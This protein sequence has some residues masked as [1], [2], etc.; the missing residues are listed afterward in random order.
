M[1]GV[2]LEAA[3][4]RLEEGRRGS[5]RSLRASGYG[6]TEA[7]RRAFAR[8]LAVTRGSTAGS[9]PRAELRWRG[10]A[11]TAR[12]RRRAGLSPH[13]PAVTSGEYRRKFAAEL[14][15]SE[16]LRAARFR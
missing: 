3:R 12:W 6:T 4:R 11:A 10:R 9:S 7:M 8:T 5:R 1:D 16:L 2:R 15:R 13:G 14:L